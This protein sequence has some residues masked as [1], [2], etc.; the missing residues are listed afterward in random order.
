MISLGNKHLESDTFKVFGNLFGTYHPVS[1]LSLGLRSSFGEGF[2]RRFSRWDRSRWASS[3]FIG[4]R[5]G[6]VCWVE[7]HGGG[8]IVFGTGLARVVQSVG[9]GRSPTSRGTKTIGNSTAGT[10]DSAER[11]GPGESSSLVGGSCFP[12]G[13][14]QHF[15]SSTDVRQIPG[16]WVSPTSIE[17]DGRTSWCILIVSTSPT[18]TDLQASTQH[19]DPD[20]HSMMHME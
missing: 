18:S 19:R 3:V 2:G 17:F 8:R 14:A 1:D 20:A 10:A 4:R 11:G 12:Q 16:G 7:N 5:V 9:G 13:T 15:S 6:G